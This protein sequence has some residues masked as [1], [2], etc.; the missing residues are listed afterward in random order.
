MKQL[1]KSYK[2][3]KINLIFTT[4]Q[5]MIDKRKIKKLVQTSN[6]GICKGMYNIFWENLRYL[7]KKN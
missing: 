7:N 3:N 6:L 5:I 2:M 1:N 4:L